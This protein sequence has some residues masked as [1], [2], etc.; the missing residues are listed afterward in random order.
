MALCSV[1]SNLCL[2]VRLTDYRECCRIDSLW[3]ANEVLVYTSIVTSLQSK[4]TTDLFSASTQMPNT[5]SL[6]ASFD[7]LDWELRRLYF[8]FWNVV[9]LHLPKQ[10]VWLISPHGESGWSR[11]T[12]NLVDLPSQGVWLISLTRRVWLISSHMDSRCTSPQGEY[13]WPPHTGNLVDLPTQ[14]VQLQLPKQGVQLHIPT[15]E[16]G[17]SPNSGVLCLATQL[18]MITATVSAHH[19][20]NI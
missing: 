13:G 2:S 16:F 17:W 1:S 6:I 14:G 15:W 5:L 11:I 3:R 8:S 12:G 9:Q 7:M 10:G 20:F 18:K 4:S 19:S